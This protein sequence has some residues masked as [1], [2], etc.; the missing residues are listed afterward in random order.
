MSL[1]MWDA[2][3]QKSLLGD[4]PRGEA[5]ILI[6]SSRIVGKQEVE[7]DA[8]RI[9]GAKSPSHEQTPRRSAPGK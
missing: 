6:N 9:A 5:L 3:G 7:R 2:V 1:M 4:R 8:F